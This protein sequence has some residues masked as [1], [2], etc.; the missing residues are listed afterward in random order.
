MRCTRPSPVVGTHAGVWTGSSG[1]DNQPCV[2]LGAVARSL[3]LILMTILKGLA[4]GGNSE[5]TWGKQVHRGGPRLLGAVCVCMRVFVCGR[6]AVSN[7]G[8]QPLLPPGI[9]EPKG[10]GPRLKLRRNNDPQQGRELEV[11]RCLGSFVTDS[12]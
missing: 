5:R 6:D 9:S 2:Q 12:G 4:M 1:G 3:C 7:S 11:A 8:L 10:S